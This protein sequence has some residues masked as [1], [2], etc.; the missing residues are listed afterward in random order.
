MMDLDFEQPGF[1]LHLTSI[2]VRLVALCC[3]RDKEKTARILYFPVVCK[4]SRLGSGV[5]DNYRVA[6][7]V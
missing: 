4:E 2:S 1:E 3:H 5:D 6:D 7:K